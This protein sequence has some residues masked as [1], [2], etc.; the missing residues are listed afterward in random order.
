[1]NA[2]RRSSRGLFIRMAI[3]CCLLALTLS[4]RGAGVAHD[5]AGA[6]DLIILRS[7]IHADGSDTVMLQLDPATLAD[8]STSFAI[9]PDVMPWTVVI[10]RDGQT[11]AGMTG[12]DTLEII[13]KRGL[14]GPILSRIPTGGGMVPQELSADGSALIVS[15]HDNGSLVGEHLTPPRARSNRRLIA[16]MATCASTSCKQLTRSHGRSTGWSRKHHR[17][18]GLRIIQGRPMLLPLTLPPATRLAGFSCQT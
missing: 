5:D 1:M 16:S 9:E 2:Q 18:Q 6:S 4:Y 3:L 14:D 15:T 7:I 8:K 13:V 11:I 12:G 10:S 17:L